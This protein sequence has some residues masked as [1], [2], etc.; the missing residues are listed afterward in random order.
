MDSQARENYLQTQVLT[1]TAQK[2]QLMLIEGAMR[3]ANQGD[4]LLAEWR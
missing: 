1:A 4:S 3:F 2:L